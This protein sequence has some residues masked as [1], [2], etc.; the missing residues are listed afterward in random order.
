[1]VN[2]LNASGIYQLQYSF[3]Y[4]G[5]IAATA[6]GLIFGVLAALIPARQATQMR[7]IQALRY[8]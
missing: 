4:G 6:A 3:P 5:V 1:M 7:I 2:G 8:E